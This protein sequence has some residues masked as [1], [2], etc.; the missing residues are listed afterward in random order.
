MAAG[1]AALAAIPICR[2]LGPHVLFQRTAVHVNLVLA[3]LKEGDENGF[4]QPTDT[5]HT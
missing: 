1:S 5:C 4:L 3:I 2:K